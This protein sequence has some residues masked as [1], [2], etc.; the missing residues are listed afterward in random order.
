LVG[1]SSTPLGLRDQTKL[2]PTHD[3]EEANQKP[4]VVSITSK[5]LLDVN[6]VKKVSKVAF[7]PLKSKAAQGP[8][9]LLICAGKEVCE[10]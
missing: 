10:S 8:T 1:L 7:T 9:M 3:L 5:V 6:V 2:G 4:M